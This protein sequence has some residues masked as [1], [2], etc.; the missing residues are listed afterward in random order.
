M[1]ISIMFY[2]NFPQFIKSRAKNLA[3]RKVMKF[4]ETKKS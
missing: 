2:A 1:L 4:D 3:R